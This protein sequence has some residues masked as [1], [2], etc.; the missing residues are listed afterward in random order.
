M[1]LIPLKICH[2]VSAADPLNGRWNKG[3]RLR[4][5]KTTEF[6]CDG[7]LTPNEH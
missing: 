3:W 1:K 7:H 2:D 6:F 4:E 5:S